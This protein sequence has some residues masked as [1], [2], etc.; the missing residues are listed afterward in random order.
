MIFLRVKEDTKN[1]QTLLIRKLLWF[2]NKIS[3]SETGEEKMSVAEEENVA[4]ETND[5][6]SKQQFTN[7]DLHNLVDL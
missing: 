2:K 3:P 7:Q 4:T 1:K 5:F 6:A